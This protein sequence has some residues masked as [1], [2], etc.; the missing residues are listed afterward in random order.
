MNDS[1]FLQ[2]GYACRMNGFQGIVSQNFLHAGDFPSLPEDKEDT[3]RNP[4][5][6]TGYHI[7]HFHLTDH[8]PLRIFRVYLKT[9]N[10]TNSEGFSA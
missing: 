10:M 4:L 6:C 7:S 9:G 3:N 1:A 8:F 5:R 2:S